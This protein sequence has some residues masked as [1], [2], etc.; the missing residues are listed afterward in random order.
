[1]LVVIESRLLML[2]RRVS[3]TLLVY[4]CFLV[5]LVFIKI[6]SVGFLVEFTWVCK[7]FNN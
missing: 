5:S 4:N 1:M 2:E 7:C 6:S 3:K